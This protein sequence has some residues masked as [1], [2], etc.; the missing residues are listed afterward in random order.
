[1]PNSKLRETWNKGFTLIELVIGIALTSI[2]ISLSFSVFSFTSKVANGVSVEDDFLLQGRFA[3]EFIKEEFSKDSPSIKSIEIV[4]MEDYLPEDFLYTDTL[5]FFI[6]KEE[7]NYKHIFYKLDGETLTRIAFETAD[8]KPNRMPVMRGNN[9]ILEDVIHIGDTYY[10]K[11][12]KLLCLVIRT[13]NKANNKEYCFME[14]IY[15]KD[16]I[17]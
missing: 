15:L 4:S 11:E 1:M 9:P 7:A 13:K 10:D 17:N 16:D 3:I 8:K 6:I 14:T 12:N 2:I 5:G